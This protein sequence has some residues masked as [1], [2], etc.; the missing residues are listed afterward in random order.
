[1]EGTVSI[2]VS[3]YDRLR[4][5]NAEIK[6]KFEKFVK[7]SKSKK[8]YLD[9]TVDFSSYDYY[10]PIFGAR[11]SSFDFKVPELVKVDAVIKK[12]MDKLSSTS[13]ELG[14]SNERISNLL[15]NLKE[16]DRELQSNEDIQKKNSRLEKENEDFREDIKNL[17]KTIEELKEKKSKRWW[18]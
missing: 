8:V 14:E 13:K 10:N 17:V 18:W 5:E 6:D 3:E 16:K 11:T 7:D 4:R 1:M 9:F 12:A 15:K 2:S